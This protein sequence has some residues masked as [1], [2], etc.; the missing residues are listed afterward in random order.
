MR[1]GL[2]RVR[3]LWLDNFVLIFFVFAQRFQRE[4]LRQLPPLHD[5]EQRAKPILTRPG[6][7]RVAGEFRRRLG[8]LFAGS[9]SRTSSLPDFP[10]QPR[11]SS[12]RFRSVELSRH[13]PRDR[14]Q[15]LFEFLWP[16]AA[17][18]LLIPAAA[19]HPAASCCRVRLF[20]TCRF[21]A[22]D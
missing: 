17:A 3:R 10:S 7:A 9:R 15:R 1:H 21:P 14:V 5:A 2:T 11:R 18:I 16:P 8:R 20:G 13:V 12:L 4:E 22:A 19:L 6:P